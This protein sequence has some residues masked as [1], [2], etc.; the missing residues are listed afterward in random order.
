[1][2]KRTTAA[3][4]TAAL[5]LGVFSATT[6]NAGAEAAPRAESTA[7]G[8]TITL[9]TGDRV[10]LPQ[11]GGKPV[12]L[13]TAE[14]KGITYQT[15][16]VDGHTHIVPLDALALI[17]AGKLDE[18][19]FDVTTLAEAG[20]D[21][22]T[23]ELPLIQTG[24]ATRAAGVRSERALNS[25]GARALSVDKA[26]LAGSWKALTAGG[27]KLWLDGKRAALL[28]RSTAP[29][30]APAAWQAGLTGKGVKVA[31]L[32]TGIDTTH[33]DLRGKVAQQ[34]TFAEDSDAI[35][36]E[37]HG[38]HVASIIAG[39]GAKYRGVAD[40]VQ[41]LDGKVLGDG[42]FG[43][44]SWIIAGMEWAAEQG[45]DVV[46]LSLGGLDGPEVD[47]VEEAVNRL[48]ARTGTLFV[49]SAGNS[50]AA[51][52]IGSPGSAE[53]ALTVGSVERDDTVSPF[54]SRGPRIGDGGVKP[55]ITAPGSGIVAAA[56]AQGQIGDPVEPGYVRLSGTSMAAPHVAGAAALLAQQHP[57]WTGAQLKA[58]LTASAKP[59]AG[60]GVFDQ[61]SGR[62]DVARALTQA[63]TTTP[64]SLS[65]G[66]QLWPHDDDVLVSK[67]LTY[68]NAGTQ[69]VTLDLRV[70]AAD[71]NDKP[72]TVFSLSANRVTVPAGGTA[73]VRVTGD[74]RRGGVDGAYSGV[75]VATG[76]QGVRTPVAIDREVESY[77]LTLRYLDPDG[78]PTQDWNTLVVPV[79]GEGAFSGTAD[80]G[81]LLKFRLPKGR[82]IL[83]NT[84]FG[85]AG[86]VLLLP[87]PA[88]RLTE[89]A[90]VV[91]DARQ[92]G[93]VSVTPPDPR[94]PVQAVRTGFDLAI[95]D[96]QA[97]FGVLGP[98]LAG[99]GV[100]HLGPE[101]SARE[102]LWALAT[103]FTDEHNYYDLAFFR[104]K[105]APRGFDRVVAR[106][107]VAVMHTS[108]GKHPP[109]TEVVRAQ[110]PIAL[111]GRGGGPTIGWPAGDQVTEHLLAANTEWVGYTVI[112]GEPALEAQW[113]TEPLR[114]TAGRTYWLR[115]NVGTFGPG[116]PK[117]RL[118]W[119][120]RFRDTVLVDLPLW[121]DGA[122]N[123]GASATTSA[124]TALYRDGKKLGESPVAGRGLFTVPTSP[125][126]YRLVTEGARDPR[127][128][129]STKVS[130]TW[131]FRTTAA[132][133]ETI[134][135]AAIRFHTFLDADNAAPTGAYVV[136]VSLQLEDGT[137]AQP[138][139]L[140]V[141]VSYD[142]GKTW[143][144]GRLVGHS[145]L[146]LNHPARATS[147]SLR[148]SAE[149]G[150]GN[151]V[152]QTIIR[153]YQLKQR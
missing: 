111:D 1:M 148:A 141:D 138:R 17:R 75:V 114:P 23:S 67:D 145:L 36:H 42:G 140:T 120:E 11:A 113:L 71:P 106:R 135:L 48:S 19:L 58:V 68:R 146:V 139:K 107:E 14:R 8:H 6:P 7:Q 55:D 129:V 60:A 62:V 104:E 39:G 63:L 80:T 26:S 124:H 84:Y 34:R 105:S 73:S 35:D 12:I 29:I 72:T 119:V 76:G 136:P 94:V 115:A 149:D 98:N 65:L 53:A 59:T 90:E 27:G 131:T 10:L 61:G 95:G 3:T 30:G 24:P 79:D 44:E 69:P 13:P 77:D 152:E 38:T 130:G 123:A 16:T 127:F 142:E 15:R 99:L 66:T 102:F 78:K 122:G 83:H 87:Y 153:A 116:L 144:K 147:V 81:G 126:S 96:L 46:N 28:D 108:V 92:T 151:S 150:R 56:A 41:L 20:Y 45:A 21:E 32:D 85:P 37:G 52:T 54:S 51:R 91:I 31:V 132:E 143:Q 101:L 117:T 82:Y 50:G 25:V 70:E 2:R 33:P 110:F 103:T 134:R 128:E 133:L 49:V 100:G 40:G 18:R 88:Y 43:R 9:I 109:G 86:E 121:T 137:T 125:G 74:T 4:I 118:P 112:T 97:S 57:E 22:R 47:P 64:G 5:I 93:K 89:S